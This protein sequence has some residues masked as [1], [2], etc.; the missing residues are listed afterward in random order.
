MS[1]LAPRTKARELTIWKG[2]ERQ[3]RDREREK[4]AHVQKE[5]IRELLLNFSAWEDRISVEE[6]LTSERPVITSLENFLHCRL[7]WNPRPR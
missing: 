7:M 4:G 2:E 3:E 1:S 6:L 5:W